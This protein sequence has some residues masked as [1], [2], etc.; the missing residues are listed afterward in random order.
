MKSWTC[1]KYTFLSFVLIQFHS[2]SQSPSCQARGKFTKTLLAM[3]SSEK[4]R[5]RNWH[6]AYPGYP[7]ILTGASPLWPLEIWWPS[8]LLDSCASSLTSQG[9]L[10]GIPSK[11]LQLSPGCHHEAKHGFVIKGKH[12]R[13]WNLSHSLPSLLRTQGIIWFFSL[14]IPKEERDTDFQQLP[15]FTQPKFSILIPRLTKGLKTCWKGRRKNRKQILVRSQNDYPAQ[16]WSNWNAE[17]GN[18]HHPELCLPIP[19]WLY[20]P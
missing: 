7:V 10:R 6:L 11:P 4:N 8:T 14:A 12:L 18:T 15:I 16:R 17:R 13:F 20:T 1:K 19:I 2:D 3:W 9:W 5:G